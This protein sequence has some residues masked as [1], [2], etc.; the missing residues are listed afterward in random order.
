[1]FEGAKEA[2]EMDFLLIAIGIGLIMMGFQIFVIWKYRR[3]IL[4]FIEVVLD[5]LEKRINKK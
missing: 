2:P 4:T 5:E 3:E 1:V